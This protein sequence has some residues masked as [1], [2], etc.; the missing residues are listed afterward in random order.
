MA[1]QGTCAQV[2]STQATMT[3]QSLL[4]G[5]FLATNKTVVFNILE[6]QLNLGFILQVAKF[7]RAGCA[8]TK[9]FYLGRIQESI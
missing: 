6:Q 8:D 1:N 7:E 4:V 2:A 5:M 9:A 3:D